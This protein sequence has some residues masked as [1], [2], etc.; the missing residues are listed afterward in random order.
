MKK[1]RSHKKNILKVL[2]SKLISITLMVT[3]IC[4]ISQPFM[5]ENVQAA[6]VSRKY[7]D[8][9]CS[10]KIDMGDILLVQRHIAAEQSYNTRI[11]NP[12]WILSDYD[13]KAG[14]INRNGKLD[15]G[16]VMS[17]QR[18]IAAENDSSI[19][20]ENPNWILN[21]SFS[22]SY[23]A[24]G[25]YVLVSALNNKKVVDLSGGSID[26]GAN[27]QLWDANN[28]YA[29]VFRLTRKGQYFFMRNIGTNKAVD[30]KGGSINKG[31]NV[32][33]YQY[34]ED[35]K[36]QMWKF[37]SA[38]N[39]YYYIRSKLGYYLDVKNG[40]TANGTNVLVWE[41]NKS[42]NQMFKLV[43]VETREPMYTQANLN[44]RASN[45]TKSEIKTV[46]PRGSLVYRYCTAGDWSLISYNGKKGYAS[47]KYLGKN[48]PDAVTVSKN[49]NALATKAESQIGY[50]GRNSKGKGKGDYTK[51]GKFTGT[52]GQF[53]CA[54]FVSW[55]VNQAGV[56]TSVVPKTAST[57]VMGQKSNSYKKWSASNFNKLK[58]GDVIFFSKTNSLTYK[59]GKKAVYHVGIVTAVD[60]TRGKITIVEGNTSSD[61]VKKNT[62]TPNT[63]SGYLGSSK[64]FCGYI[65]VK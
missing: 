32:Q 50:Q 27:I 23:P 16:D 9:N 21:G 26:N 13:F 36:A 2:C 25:Y 11:E 51:Y 63:S 60:R 39:G 48:K 40:N 56:S 31:T 54:S 49:A 24:S 46:M 64:Y 17:I 22:C 4:G 59:D 10:G 20:A 47:S 33:Q 58:R 65:S 42:K 19:R 45:S 57:L 1:K 55:C 28:T 41:M 52:N 44:L 29:Q 14:D 12:D 62:Y 34:S 5:S 30:V 8:V 53:W 15:M 37:E 38:G 18:H 35:N 61:V 43:N 6:T 3:L 7:G